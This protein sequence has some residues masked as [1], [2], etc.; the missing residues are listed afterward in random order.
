MEKDNEEL[1]LKKISIVKKIIFLLSQWYQ[2][3]KEPITTKNS[4]EN[5]RT[6]LH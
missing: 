2:K 3:Q 1:M 5:F 6:I 4:T